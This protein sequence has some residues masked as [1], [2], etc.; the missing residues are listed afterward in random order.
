M[1]KC[2]TPPTSKHKSRDDKRPHHKGEVHYVQIQG[3]CHTVGK[4][5]VKGQV[6]IEDNTPPPARAGAAGV[7]DTF[8]PP[9]PAAKRLRLLEPPS[10]P[11]PASKRLLGAESPPPWDSDLQRDA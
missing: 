9:A 5:L 8:T 10:S 4:M 2:F 1:I 11:A 3:D 6:K 7:V